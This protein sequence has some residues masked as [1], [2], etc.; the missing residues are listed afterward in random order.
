MKRTIG[1][2]RWWIISVVMIGTSLNYLTRSTLG[3]AAPTVLADLSIGERE[4]GLITAAFQ[5]G[6]MLQPVAGYLLDLIGLRIGL[7]AFA[8]AWAAITIAH[9][10]A[11]GWHSLLALRAALGFAEGTAH[12]GGLKV[13]SQWFPARERGFA[14][15]IYNIGASVGSMVAPPLVAAAILLWNWRAA[16]FI[17]GLMAAVWVVLWLLVYRTPADHPRISAE[18]REQIAAGR[19]AHLVERERRPLSKLLR[20]RNLWGLALPRFLADPTWGTLTFWLPLYLTTTRGFDLKQI[21]MFAWLP[22]VAAD[23]GCLAGPAAAAWLHKRG[24]SLINARRW[25]F[26]MGAALMIC[27]IFV[28]RVAS[29]YAA[30]ALLCI[31]GFAHQMLSVTCITMATDLFPQN[32]VGTVSGLAG[33]FANLGVLLFSLAIGGLV[34]TVGYDPFFIALSLLDL[35][36]AAV[37]WTVIRAP[38]VPE[39]AISETALVEKPL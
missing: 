6:I 12:P 8:S 27:M 33:T 17:V 31:G 4:Y 28:P 7:A 35:V 26:T 9:G 22:F 1:G 18:E 16:F 32:E 21:A 13:V 20:E 36:A 30:I 23:I 34:A 19:E 3:V 39:P 29:P 15:G 37:L 11:G 25:A 24:V 2:L 10:F 14:G 38:S 5:L